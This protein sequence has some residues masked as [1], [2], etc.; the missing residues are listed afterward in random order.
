MQHA[1]PGN[2]D[3]KPALPVLEY[4][5]PLVLFR[6]QFRTRSA[7]SIIG[8]IIV[9][10]MGT[11]AFGIPHW[12]PSTMAADPIGRLVLVV[13]RCAGVACSA[14]VIYAIWQAIAG[15]RWEILIT[16]DGITRNG[17]FYPWQ[18]IRCFSAIRIRNHHAAMQFAFNEEFPVPHGLPLTPELSV[19]EYSTLARSL[20]RCLGERYPN[21]TVEFEP[22]DEAG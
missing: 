3:P 15:V 21:L 17:R 1:E 19:D 14:L 18:D 10:L 20:H 8:I 4:A 12:A 7:N 9:S 11:V 16:E 6:G 13:F 22:H 5:A 2:P